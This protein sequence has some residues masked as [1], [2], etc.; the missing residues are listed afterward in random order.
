[1]ELR[2]Y[3]QASLDKLYHWWQAHPGIDQAPLVVIPT[4]GGKSWII[5]ELTRQLW[6]TWPEDHPRTLVLVPS[7]ELAEQNAE[8]LAALLPNHIHLDY[9]SASLGRKRP[10]A[11][12]IVATIGS[13]YRQAHLLGD[14]KMVIV[15]E[16]FVGSTKISTPKG[17]IKIDKLR[18][19]DAILCAT[20]VAHIVSTRCR[21]PNQLIEVFFDDGT[22][23]RCTPNHRFFTD[24]GWCEARN[25]E[26][27]VAFREQAMR[28]LWEGLLSNQEKQLGDTGTCMEQAAMLQSIL[29][30][31]VKEPDEQ[32]SG[33]AKNARAFDRDQA[34]THQTG[35]QRRIIESAATSFTARFG[36]WVASGASGSDENGQGQWLSDL[37]QT[38]CRKP[39]YEDRNRGGR[40]FSHES[41]AES[42]GHQ[43]GKVFGYSRVVR[44]SRI[45]P[46]S[47][48]PVFNLHVDR[49]P[50]YFANDRL[51]HNCHLVNPDGAGRY[52][53]LLKDLSQYCKFRVMG[54]TATPFRG[55]GVWLTDGKDPLFSGIAYDVPMEELFKAGYLAPLVRPMDAITTKIDVSGISTSGGDYHL[56]D[57]GDRVGEYLIAAADETLTLAADRKKWLAFCPTVATA[58]QLVDLLREREI[59]VALVTGE[60]PKQERAN[61][62]SDFRAGRLRCLVTVLALAIG[63]DVPDVDCLIWLRPTISPVLYLQGAGR[64]LRIAEEKRDC[65]WI[66]YTDTT[67]RLGPIDKIKGRKKGKG[68]TDPQAPYAICDNCGA[69]VRP[70]SLTNCPECGALLR[71]PEAKS[72]VGASVA[73]V[74]SRQL[75]KPN[76]VRYPVDR[77]TYHRHVKPGSPDSM[78]V[79]Y[80][81]GLRVVAKEWVC[82]EHGGMAGYKAKQ[83][84]KFRARDAIASADYQTGNCTTSGALELLHGDGPSDGSPWLHF[85][86]PE[87]INVNESAKFPEI[88]SFEWRHEDE[89]S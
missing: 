56:D 55:N 54:T 41:G 4:G 27:K 46:E 52:R 50:S 23:I 62:I 44:V 40:I 3:Q 86:T 15:D 74:L 88:V 85:A 33:K 67:A 79:E 81:S 25:M 48:E 77:V 76:I 35:W 19:G 28:I 51:V 14:I 59:A 57:L 11:D 69:Q 78:R 24:N 16:C 89:Q 9:Y 5:A 42:E 7:K 21:F 53:K 47:L 61:L 70:A 6:D 65:L 1:M 29:L 84:I 34:Q 64:G 36:R 26:G 13:V 58:L 80:W 71:E 22:S 60:T 49:H 66:D 72:F 12:V 87:A 8:K 20:G 83:W 37:L 75:A 30:E 39:I 32:A 73:A 43:E 18:P 68:Q 17:L 63:F 45:E 31:E 82:F 38:G 2:Q 10:D